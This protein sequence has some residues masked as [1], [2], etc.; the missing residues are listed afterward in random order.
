MG[1]F[2]FIGSCISAVGSFFSGA[3]K[4]ASSIISKIPV[5]G[6]VMG[7][8][9]NPILDIAIKVGKAIFEGIVRI[10]S[11]VAKILG[12]IPEKTEP[13]EL[14]ERA[15]QNPNIKREDFES[16]DAFIKALQEAPFDEAKFEEIK[17]NNPAEL[18]ADTAIGLGIEQKAIEEK[19]KMA[20][21]MEFFEAG[22]KG[23]MSPENMKTVLTAM[24]NSGLR[25]AGVFATYLAGGTLSSANNEKLQA[26]FAENEKN[27]GMPIS[28]IETNVNNYKPP[29]ES[30]EA[31]AAQLA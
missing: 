30:G 24:S 10:V 9:T 19:V 15:R 22:F 27:G 18:M 23:G 29:V 12:I 17:K 26:A 2:S 6:P 3:C 28:Q 21:P 1:L 13:D 14:G 31:S 20:V 7:P 8:I 5:L 4:A 25:D 11:E 16:T